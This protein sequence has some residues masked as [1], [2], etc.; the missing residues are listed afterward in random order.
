MKTIAFIIM[1]ILNLACSTDNKDAREWRQE[2][3]KA[4]SECTSKGI[5]YF[6]SIG[7]YPT[8]SSGDDA[9][10]TAKERCI[11]QPYTAF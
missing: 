4:I 3:D 11:K 9:K 2:R 1:I 7:S 6:K 8:L 10:Y 5:A